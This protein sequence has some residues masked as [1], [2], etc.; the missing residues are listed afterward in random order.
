MGI[1]PKRIKFDVTVCT[2]NNVYDASKNEVVSVQVGEV[3]HRDIGLLQLINLFRNC[4]S[5]MLA[6]YDSMRKEFH[7]VAI[8]VGGPR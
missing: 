5:D 6:T 8:G 3:T 7:I 4:E 2:F 1:L